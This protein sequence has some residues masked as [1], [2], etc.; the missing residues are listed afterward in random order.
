MSKVYNPHLYGMYLLNKEELKNNDDN[1]FGVQ[2]LM[3]YHATSPSNAKEIAKNNIDWRMT[4]R[5]RYGCGACFSKSP[6]Y[7]NRHASS[8]GG[9]YFY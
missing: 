4:N 6:A 9:K 2:E 1:N 5:S 3:L 7:A 8:T